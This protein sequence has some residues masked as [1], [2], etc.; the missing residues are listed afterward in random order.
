M[1][2][3]MNFGQPFMYGLNGGGV[4]DDTEVR[5]RKH[6]EVQQV[7]QICLSS[8]ERKWNFALSSGD[9]SGNRHPRALD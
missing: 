6:L 3:G 8:F 4:E 9:A 1:L 7:W 2:D 5:R